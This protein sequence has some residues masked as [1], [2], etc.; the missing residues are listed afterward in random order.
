MKDV[1][2]GYP[3]VL[4]GEKMLVQCIKNTGTKFSNFI[5]KISQLNLDYVPTHHGQSG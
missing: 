1:I 4:I 3:G 2:S 5:T